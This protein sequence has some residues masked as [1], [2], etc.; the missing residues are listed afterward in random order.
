L[1][2]RAKLK[3]WSH[4]KFVIYI[5]WVRNIIFIIDGEDTTEKWKIIYLNCGERYEDM[6]ALILQLLLNCN[7]QLILSSVLMLLCIFI[8][9]FLLHLSATSNSCRWNKGI[10]NLFV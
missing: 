10:F 2:C 9:R 7:D 1:S 4:C 8:L 5:L 3:S 6:I